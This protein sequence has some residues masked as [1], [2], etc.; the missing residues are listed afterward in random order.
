VQPIFQQSCGGELCHNGT[1]GPTFP[2][3]QL[4]NA[5]VQR[6]TCAGVGVR[7]TAASLD[8][9]YL[10]HKVTG[11]G[12]CPGTVQMPK[13]GALPAADIQAIADWICAGAQND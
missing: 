9:S 4:V 2:Y 11:I 12:M 8:K 1:A 6:D 3:D 10:M 5:P 7:V 13:G